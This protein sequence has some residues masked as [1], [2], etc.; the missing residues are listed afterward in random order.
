[1][2]DEGEFDPA[3]YCALVVDPNHY[4]R[5]IALDQ[6][7]AMGMRRVLAASDVAEAW[8]MLCLKKPDIVLVEWMAESGD[9]LDF[10]RRV[11]MSEGVHNRAVPIFMLTARGAFTDVES[12]RAAGV[13]GYLRKPISTLE[14]RKRLRKVVL[15]PQPFV[16][17]ATYVGPC[18]RRRQDPLYKGPFRRVDDP[19]APQMVGEDEVSVS[20]ARARVATLEAYARDLV[21]GDQA[22]ARKV[23]Q[24]AQA[25]H[26]VAQDIQDANLAFATRE[27]MRY[28]K[29]Q[30]ATNRLDADVVRTHVAALHQLA[31]IPH[32]LGDERD[33]VAQGLKRMVDKKLRGHAG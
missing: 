24:A 21:S 13:D 6:L 20:L 22:A 33:R 26:D 25:L 30:G 23:Y 11:R 15:N 12:A 17:T 1:M 10:V 7:R 2:S 9:G 16:V 27:M 5:S 32:A 31:H 8:E 29:S 14:V 19:V 28:F 4:H 18:R 3:A